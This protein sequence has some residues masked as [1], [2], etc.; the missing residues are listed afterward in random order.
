MPDSS[1]ANRQRRLSPG[2]TLLEVLVAL[3][4]FALA[5]VVLGTAYVNVLLGYDTM[6]RRQGRDETVRM[7][8][9]ALLT[10][11]DRT[12]AEQGADFVLPNGRTGQWRA[13]IEETAVADL[14]TVAFHCE[15]PEADQSQPRTYDQVLMLLRPTWSDPAVREKLRGDARDRLAKRQSP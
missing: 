4:I 5:A 3:A 12:K 9:A 1:R 11:P 15:V 14:F 8:R 13:Q 10:Q 2:F 6:T 7:M